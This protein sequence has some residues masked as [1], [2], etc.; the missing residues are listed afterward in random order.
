MALETRLAKVWKKKTGTDLLL[1]WA[2]STVN[3]AI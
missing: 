1:G 3:V 2:Y